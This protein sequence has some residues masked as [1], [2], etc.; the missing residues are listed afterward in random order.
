LPQPSA[1]PALV[2]PPA[3]DLSVPSDGALQTAFLAGGCFGGVEAIFEHVKG[4]VDVVSGYSGGTAETAIYDLVVFG[5]TSH[6]EVVEVHFDPTQISY[7]QILRV[8]FSV[9][10]D[11]TQVDRQGPDVGPAYRS[12]IFFGDEAHGNVAR[13][14][15]AQLAGAF[16]RPIATRIDPLEA[17]YPA[18]D[19]HQD[20]LVKNPSDPYIVKYDLPLLA[21]LQLL[22]PDLYRS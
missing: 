7:G 14:Y 2:P 8:Y 21:E 11:P 15:V 6:A 13:A 22:F 17:F 5:L 9:A 4:V 10:H 20:F 3:L 12:H 16:S 1:P 18:G 19:Y